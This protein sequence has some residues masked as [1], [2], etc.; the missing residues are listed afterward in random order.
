MKLHAKQVLPPLTQMLEERPP[1]LQQLVQTTIAMIL[2]CP[3]EVF[4]QQIGHRTVGEPFSV[5]APLAARINQPVDRQR[6]QDVF[7][8]GAFARSRQSLRPEGDRKS[9][10]LNSS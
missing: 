6:L 9:T 2:L 7:P 1:M 10:R 3:A 4:A 5:Q 8:T